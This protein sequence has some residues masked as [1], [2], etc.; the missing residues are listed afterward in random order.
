MGVYVLEGGGV[1]CRKGNN[2]LCV[3][4]RKTVRV[5]GG[6]GGIG[7]STAS[8]MEKRRRR[9]NVC[10]GGCMGEG[11]GAKKTVGILG[12]QISVTSPICQ[13]GFSSPPPHPTV[14]SLASLWG[15]AGFKSTGATSDT[16]L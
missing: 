8:A 1:G 12:P 14:Q 4:A 5:E 2:A 16:V 13:Y 11:V 9:Q 15:M 3:F 10:V 6:G 7:S